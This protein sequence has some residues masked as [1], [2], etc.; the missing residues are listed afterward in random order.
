MVNVEPGNLTILPRGD[1]GL[2]G[3]FLLVVLAWVKMKK[4]AKSWER[5]RRVMG[6][7]SAC[8]GEGGGGAMDVK[9]LHTLVKDSDFVGRTEAETP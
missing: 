8:G 4:R 5:P 6:I 2:L 1:A 9:K 7:G 3:R